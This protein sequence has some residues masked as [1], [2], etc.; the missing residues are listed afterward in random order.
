VNLVL[1]GYRGVGKT[2]VAQQLGLRLGWEWVD[3]DVELEFRA[4]KSIAAMFAAEGEAAFR[5]LEAAVLAD[6]LARDRVVVAAGGGVVLRSANR[7]LLRQ[8]AGKVVWLK[9]SVP[10]ILERVS[11]DRTTTERRPSLTTAG[12]E[13]EIRELLA[14]RTPLYR[15]CSHLEI[16]TDGRAPDDIAA[17]IVAEMRRSFGEPA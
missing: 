6:L 16:D 1:I 8:R 4:G 10:T 12:G 5:D 2:T 11:A 17:T 3:A 13:T 15:Q 9:A 7:D 14:E